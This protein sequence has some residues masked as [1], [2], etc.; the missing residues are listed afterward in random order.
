MADAADTT[1]VLNGLVLPS[2]MDFN[3]FNPKDIKSITVYKDLS[4]FLKDTESKFFKDGDFFEELPDMENLVA[5]IISLQTKNAVLEDV[6][7]VLESRIAS[8]RKVLDEDKSLVESTR[9]TLEATVQ[10]L[11]GQ[12]DAIRA[13]DGKPVTA[14]VRASGHGKGGRV[15]IS[16]S[17]ID[18]KVSIKSVKKDKDGG[19]LEISSPEGKAGRVFIMDGRKLSE[20]EFVKVDTENIKSITI[21]KGKELPEEFGKYKG[22][23]VVSIRSKEEK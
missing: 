13:F 19:R 6:R 12:L 14:A 17:D 7:N 9:G 10:E 22:K 5:P 4:K 2:G 23:T 16:D 20:K 3:C 15:T 21:Y 18:G 11:E 1:Y 8:I